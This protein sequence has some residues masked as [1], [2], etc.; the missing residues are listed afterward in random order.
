MI[1]KTIPKQIWKWFTSPR[2][3]VT[4][5]QWRSSQ[6]LTRMEISTLLDVPE[7]KTVFDN[8]FVNQI[9]TRKLELEKSYWRMSVVATVL[10]GFL[11]VNLFSLNVDLNF[12]GL[13]LKANGSLREAALFIISCIGVV[14]ALQRTQIADIE[15]FLKEY[16]KSRIGRRAEE[17]YRLRHSP[18]LGSS[19]IKHFSPHDL[20][21]SS[22]TKFLYLLF[23]FLIIVYGLVFWGFCIAVHVFTIT[24][25]VKEPSLPWMWSY[26]ILLMVIIADIILFLLY[27]LIYLPLPY[28]DHSIVNELVDLKIRDPNKWR[29]KAKNLV[30]PSLKRAFFG[31]R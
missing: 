7:L 12:L 5:L 15:S 24:A 14:T 28:V 1:S 22:I 27:V 30:K 2:V 16:G 29:E 8:D 6:Q 10:T 9:S 17:I 23:L 3:R 25:I 19:F 4:S 20:V 13:A 21:I 26:I 18:L 31:G 11:V